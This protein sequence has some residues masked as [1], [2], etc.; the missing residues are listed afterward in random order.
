MAE[1]I[2]DEIGDRTLVPGVYSEVDDSRAAGTAIGL[3][4]RILI[5][6]GRTSSG[7]VAAGVLTRITGDGQAPV[8]F[9]A[10]SMLAQMIETARGFS[11]SARRV[12]M[13]ALAVDDGG[14]AVAATG[15]IALSGTATSALPLIY[16]VGGKRVVVPVSVGD[17][18]AEIATAAAALDHTH[19]AVTAADGTGSIDFTARNDGPQGNDIDI[20]VLQRPAGIT[21]TV[22]AMANGATAPSFTAAISAIGGSQWTHIALGYADDDSVDDFE[23]ELERRAGPMV[24]QWGHLFVGYRG[25]LA[26][27][28]IYGAA[29]NS[30]YSTVGHMHLAPSTPWEIAAWTCM[31]DAER[32]DPARPRNGVSGATRGFNGTGRGGLTPTRME[33]FLI[34]EDFQQLL[35][36]G[37]TPLKVDEFARISVV[38]MV[39]TRQLDDNGLASDVYLDITT[40]R[41]L[42]ALIY[43]WE[44]TIKTKYPA[45]KKDDDG[46]EPVGGVVTPSI[47]RAEALALWDGLWVPSGWVQSSK[48]SE[49]A[50]EILVENHPTDVNRFNIRIPPHLIRGA[51][52][53]ATQFSFRL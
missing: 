44:V 36:A 34:D 51:H 3:P 14:A 25:S 21:S 10:G 40:P 50:S 42:A 47:I 24:D 39:T 19:T 35:D 1:I 32:D 45:A 27:A 13:Y 49:F 26:N 15:D 41:T 23:A 7:T 43:T 46:G 48:R 11:T 16:L 4:K 9:G 5:V 53:F 33:D 28:L 8:F 6:G 38:R 30:Q 22:T 37:I 31:A 18:A 52:V 20:R 29:R 2:F 17:T 12:E